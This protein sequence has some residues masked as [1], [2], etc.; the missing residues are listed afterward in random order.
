MGIFSKV[1]YFLNL[2]QFLRLGEIVAVLTTEQYLELFWFM[3]S[4]PDFSRNGWNSRS[5]Q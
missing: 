5:L 3:F 2:V 4:L 1:K